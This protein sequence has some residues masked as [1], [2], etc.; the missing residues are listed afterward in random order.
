M[1][2]WLER[3]DSAGMIL[4]HTSGTSGKLSFIPRSQTE[5]RGVAARLRA[6]AGSDG[7]RHRERERTVVLARLTGRVITCRSRLHTSSRSARGWGGGPLRALRLR[8]VVGSDCRWRAGC[9]R[10]K[11]AASWTSWSRPGVAG[12]AGAADRGRPKH[13]DEDLESWFTKL[14]QEYQGAQGVDSRGQGGD[15]PCSPC[16]VRNRAAVRVRPRFGSAHR[17]VA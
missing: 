14:A 1:D 7:R 10:P 16:A 13:R 3:L 11:S 9:A 17:P 6:C 4:G 2:E 15:G 8:H 12:E 5:W